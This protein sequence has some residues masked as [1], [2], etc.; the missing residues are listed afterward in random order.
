M[1]SNPEKTKNKDDKTKIKIETFD[2]ANVPLG[3]QAI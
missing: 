3:S 2:C 1:R